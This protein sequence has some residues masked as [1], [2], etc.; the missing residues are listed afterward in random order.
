MKK[1]VAIFGGSFDPPHIAH[2][3]VATFVLSMEDSVDELWVVPCYQHPFSKTLAPFDDRLA[4]CRRAFDWLPQTKVSTVE[5]DLGGESRTI[6]TLTHLAREEPK[7]KL[8]L[9]IGTDIMA[10]A[11][12]WQSFDKICKVAPPIVL[13][14]RGWEELGS[15][16]QGGQ[17]SVGEFPA[18]SSTQIREAIS[19]GNLSQVRNWVPPNVLSYALDK[20]LYRPEQ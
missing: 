11:P 16:K 18:V 6:R 20:G 14:R 1:T 8:R 4:M 13:A 12:R 7:L 9:V 17:A 19:S 3:L 2:I 10:E 15:A 5:R